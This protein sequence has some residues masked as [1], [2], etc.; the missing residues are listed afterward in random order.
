MP[1]ELPRRC[2]IRASALLSTAETEQYLR[3]HYFLPLETLETHA[4][5][6]L[7]LRHETVARV[8]AESGY[9]RRERNVKPSA[10]SAGAGPQTTTMEFAFVETDLNKALTVQARFFF[11][12]SDWPD[13]SFSGFYGVELH[14]ER[15][16]RWAKPDAEINL[17]LSPN[18]YRLALELGPLCDL[19]RKPDVCFAFNNTP[20]PAVKLSLEGT[21]L[22]FEIGA[23]QCQPTGEQR[24]TIRSPALDT[25]SWEFRD[26]RCLGLPVFGVHVA[27]LQDR[28]PAD[29]NRRMTRWRNLMRAF[30]WASSDDG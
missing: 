9:L 5:S 6:G 15:Y 7:L 25:A 23:E 13:G 18:N 14:H 21:C 22:G 24:L 12:A 26:P 27:C 30:G 8:L 1:I 19:S 10:R 2:W 28:G 17:N 29:I 11:D 20:V 3:Q 16:F 4:K